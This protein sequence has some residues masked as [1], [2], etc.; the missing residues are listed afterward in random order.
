MAIDDTPGEQPPP[1][2]SIAERLSDVPGTPDDVANRLARSVAKARIANALFA[3][4]RQVDIGRYRLLERAGWGG[5][6]VVWS[7]WDPE[8]ERRVA[9]KLVRARVKTAREQIQREGQALAKL[10]HPNV[11]SI[12]DVGVIDDQVYLVMEWVRGATLRELC[13]GDHSTREIVHVY[14]QVCAG[15]AAAHRAGVIHRDFKPENAIRGEDGRVRVLDFGLAVGE[16]VAGSSAGTP[17]YMAPEQAAGLVVTAA[18]DQYA[19][20]T[21]LREALVGGRVG[22]IP[23]WLQAIVSRGT[24]QHP[25][26]RFPTM[27]ALAAALED[28]P[29]RRWRRRGAVSATAAGV[30]L[31][32]A[33]GRARSTEPP[34]ARC[35]AAGQHI[36]AIWN[37]NARQGVSDHLRSLGAFGAHEAARLVGELTAY[38]SAWASARTEAC[39]AYNRGQLPPVLYEQ[40]LRCL[41]R[42]EAAFTAAI[43]VAT[44]V[45]ADKLSSALIGARSLPSP[46]GCAGEDVVAVAPPPQ[47]VAAKVTEIAAAVER[48]RVLTLAASP[49]AVGAANSAAQA[50]QATGYAPLLAR[51]MMVQGWARM[52]AD[53]DSAQELLDRA[54]HVALRA[55]DDVLAVEAYARAWYVAARTSDFQ[56]SEPERALV[57]DLATRTGDSGRFVRALFY[58]NLATARLATSDRAGA[59]DLLR[60]ALIAW[61]PPLED[62]AHDIELNSVLRNLALVEDEPARRLELCRRAIDSLEVRLGP[63]HPD[64]IDARIQLAL[65]TTNPNAAARAFARTCAAIPAWQPQLKAECSYGEAWLALDRGDEPRALAA[66]TVAHAGSGDSPQRAIAGGYLD[67]ASGDRVRILTARDALR[68]LGAR[69]MAA[70]KGWW[71]HA[72]AADAW[73]MVA[74]ADDAVGQGAAS[75]QSWQIALSLLGDHAV[76]ERRKARAHVTLAKRWIQ[77]RPMEAH[78]HALAALLWYRKAGGYETEIVE[79]THLADTN[80]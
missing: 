53:R 25:S 69:L 2:D 21:A 51:S 15:L 73:I 41:G 76:L 24:S 30:A 65:L 12:F 50:A 18:A 80:Q 79:L 63:E 32:F 31:A 33:I 52:R 39:L 27:E 77:S 59:R 10:S 5:M 37:P 68:H 11:V 29:A 49:R 19:C 58:N 40:R 22:S 62:R 74:L 17:R 13:R 3:S 67:I 6:G 78:R 1:Q 43:E 38:G 26:D 66:M 45:Q 60:Q 48:A 4:E 75:T 9:I 46:A 42:S 20:C 14:R 44:E 56:P 35:D 47:A 36:S 57:E 61:R 55:G 7:A 72:T 28:N 71:D 64:T 16:A 54:F 8:L 70:D 23:R 34:G